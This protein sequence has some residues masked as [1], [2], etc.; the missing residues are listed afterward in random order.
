MFGATPG[1]GLGGDGVLVNGGT[2][3]GRGVS[4]KKRSC[5]LPSLGRGGTWSGSLKPHRLINLHREDQ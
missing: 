3:R 5:S 4:G 1:G 2:G